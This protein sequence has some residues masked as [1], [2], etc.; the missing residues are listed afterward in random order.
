VKG[1]KDIPAFHVVAPSLVDFGF[2]SG[3]KKVSSDL[4]IC[5]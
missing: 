3:S 1:G 4:S 5:L 2:S